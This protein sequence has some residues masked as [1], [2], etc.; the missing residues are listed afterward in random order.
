MSGSASGV[1]LITGV[2]GQDGVYLARHLLATGTRVIG[3]VRP[4]SD[5]ARWMAPYLQGVDVVEVDV[6][7]AAGIIDLVQRDEVEEI[8]N[9]AAQSSVGT[10]WTDP[11]MTHAINAIAVEDLIA[12]LVRLESRTGR[13]VRLFQ[14][15]SAEERSGATASPYA[16]SK[17]AARAAVE[18]ARNTAGLEASVCTLF[19][20]ESPLRGPQFVTRK[21]TRAVAE[22]ERGERET[23]TLGNLDVARDWG[24]A[25][26]YV[27]AMSAA[28][29]ADPPVDVEI[30]T[31]RSWPLAQVLAAAFAAIG[32]ADHGPHVRQDPQLM[33]P[34]DV[35]DQVGDPSAAHELL[36]WTA[37]MSFKDLIAHMVDVDRR[38]LAS[39]VEHD[40]AYLLP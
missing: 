22:I 6:R 18:R 20:H 28:L 4:A 15:G 39:S 27:T 26:D 17:A 40:P 5:E 10:S 19:N 24:F 38:R 9:L 23:L 33:R 32:V 34:A 14:P 2:A 7:D 13:R 35:P 11:G 31:G 21:I 1:A 30:A 3:A 25:G 36:G 16:T 12:A 8:F 29:R 37:T